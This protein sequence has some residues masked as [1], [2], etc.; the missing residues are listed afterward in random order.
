MRQHLAQVD[1]GSPDLGKFAGS[2]PQAFAGLLP[3]LGRL[4]PLSK[5]PQHFRRALRIRFRAITALFLLLLRLRGSLLLLLS[6]VL[7]IAV[8]RLCIAS[9]LFRFLI[10]IR[11]GL[12]LR[13][14]ILLA[15]IVAGFFL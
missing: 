12:L 2:L 14:A 11:L 7:R 9:A 15:G 1:S 6:R 3:L 4:T 13:L 8:S 5:F 10:G